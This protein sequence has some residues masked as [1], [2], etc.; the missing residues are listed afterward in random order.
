MSAKGNPYDNA[1]M[2]S[3]IKSLK[4]EEIHLKHYDYIEDVFRNLPT[5]IEEIY[6]T[7]RLHS[8]LG[9]KTPTEFEEEIEN[10]H[11]SDKPLMI[12]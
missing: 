5:F 1:F 11:D 8:S 2:E 12:L 3:C 9:Y 6:N 10:I 4:Q 7:K